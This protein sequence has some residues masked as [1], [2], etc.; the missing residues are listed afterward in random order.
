VVDEPAFVDALAQRQIR[1]IAL[2]VTVEESLPA[3][4]ALWARGARAHCHRERPINFIRKSAGK[5]E[6]DDRVERSLFGS[7]PP[8]P[9]CPVW[10]VPVQHTPRAP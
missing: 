6:A 7:S 4:S 9:R 10:S 8:N 3:A 1:A 2:D 5:K